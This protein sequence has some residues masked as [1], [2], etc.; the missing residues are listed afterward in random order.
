M[1][2]VAIDPLEEQIDEDACATARALLPE[3]AFETAWQ[4]GVALPLD[5]AIAYALSVTRED[6][7]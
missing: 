7:R 3:G 5:E 6:S 2:G 4:S 1:M